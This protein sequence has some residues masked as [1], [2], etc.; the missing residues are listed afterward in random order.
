[1]PCTRVRTAN[2]FALDPPHV[3]RNWN[4]R[5]KLEIQKNAIRKS[6][7]ISDRE[8]QNCYEQISNRLHFDTLRCSPSHS[9][10]KLQSSCL[11]RRRFP[12]HSHTDALP[13]LLIL[14]SAP[15]EATIS[16]WLRAMMVSRDLSGN[17]EPSE[18]EID[19]RRSVESE[20]R[21][22]DDSRTRF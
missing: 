21:L 9:A 14:N 1:M 8:K 5:S 17:T 15:N 6:Y 16:I 2:F 7:K 22:D 3:L 12:T 13:G 4:D 19:T 10:T 11:A 20:S 18:N